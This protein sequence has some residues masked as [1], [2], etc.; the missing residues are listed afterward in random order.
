[1]KQVECDGY[2]FKFPGALAAFKFDSTEP[3]DPYYH[4]VPMKAVDVVAEF[5]N[6]YVFIEIKN[7]HN[8]DKYDEGTAESKEDL[9]DI[10]GAYN[11]LKSVLKYKCRDSLL[12]RV[13]ENKA[14]KPVHYICLMN[15][16]PSTLHGLAKVLSKELPVGYASTRWKRPLVVS[17][18]IINE[19]LFKRLFPHWSLEQIIS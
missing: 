1:M 11:T 18:S 4:G 12:F 7:F 8:I 5:E 9:Q 10:R 15:L 19:F 14:Y 3:D 17:Y 6:A 16:N 2:R 13:A